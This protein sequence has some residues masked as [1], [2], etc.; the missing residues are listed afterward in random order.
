MIRK[1]ELIVE[2]FE[3]EKS[4]QYIMEYGVAEELKDV[5]E[6]MKHNTGGKTC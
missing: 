5:I 2:L 6:Y 1:L 3:R 4:Q